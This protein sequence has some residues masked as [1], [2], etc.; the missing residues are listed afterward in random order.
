[1]SHHSNNKRRKITHSSANSFAGISLDS[2]TKLALRSP[3]ARL[4]PFLE[5]VDVMQREDNDGLCCCE[6]PAHKRD[7]L[8]QGRDL[9]GGCR[10]CCE[11]VRRYLCLCLQLRR[12]MSGTGPVKLAKDDEDEEVRRL[13]EE[14]DGVEEKEKCEA[15]RFPP[16]E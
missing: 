13:E 11:A 2:N 1:M 5:A 7:K 14:D 3:M 8:G 6:K 4:V 12:T 9:K 16:L 15:V 10:G